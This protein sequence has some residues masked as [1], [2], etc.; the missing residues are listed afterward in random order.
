MT[1]CLRQNAVNWSM[2]VWKDTLWLFLSF[3][4]WHKCLVSIDFGGAPSE[5]LYK[6]LYKPI[7]MARTW[8]VALS[9]SQL[10]LKWDETLVLPPGATE[11]NSGISRTVSDLANEERER[12]LAPHSLWDEGINH[13]TKLLPVSKWI[14]VPTWSC[15]LIFSL[16]IFFLLLPFFLLCLAQQIP[17]PACPGNQKGLRFERAVVCTDGASAEGLLLLFTM[18]NLAVGKLSNPPL[19]GIAM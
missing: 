3:L 4:Q 6:L 15:R 1:F 11:G 12:R 13:L 14:C 18:L 7:Y 5:P 16:D 8:E 2:Q 9:D 17:V 19:P 10:H